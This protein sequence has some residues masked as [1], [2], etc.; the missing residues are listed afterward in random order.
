[1]RRLV[2]N[3]LSSFHPETVRLRTPASPHAAAKF[4]G[5]RIALEELRPPPAIPGRPLVIEGAGGVLAPLNDRDSM[6][7]LIQKLGC[8][9][10]VVSRNYLGSINHSLLTIEALQRR[11]IEILGLVFNGEE[12]PDTES[13][14]LS[15]TGVALLGSV[16]WETALTPELIR[17]YA[18]GFAA[19][20]SR[21]MAER[22]I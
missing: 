4:E 22:T 2:T 16:R 21:Q 13:L 10:V 12:N 6:I 8:E 11:E 14:I 1:M 7:D 20:L 9:A 17:R 18:D 19:V 15:R 5:R 3:K